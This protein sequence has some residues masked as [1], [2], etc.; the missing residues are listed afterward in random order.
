M[1]TFRAFA[2]FALA[3][4]LAATA[5]AGDTSA[6]RRFEWST[7]SA[8]ARQLL[9]GCVDQVGHVVHLAKGVFAGLGVRKVNRDQ[10]RAGEIVGDAPGDAD[11]VPA[12]QRGEVVDGR[13]ADEPRCSRH[14]DFLVR[15]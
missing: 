7:Q 11:H 8:E 12:G 4:A 6:G 13:V 1:R 10:A 2:A 5:A 14:E 9:K 15:A 3:I